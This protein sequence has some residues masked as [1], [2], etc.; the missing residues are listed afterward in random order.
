[1]ASVVSNWAARGGRR[2]VWVGAVA[3]VLLAGAAGVSLAHPAAPAS[4]TAGAVFLLEVP[5]SSTANQTNSISIGLDPAGGM[6]AGFTTIS[7]DG[8]GNHHA[9]YDFCAAGADC[10]TTANWTR[11]TLLTVDSDTTLMHGGQL[12][13]NAQGDPR[14]V[15]ITG[16]RDD[17]YLDHYHYAACDSGCT[18]FANWT[19]VDVAQAG[20]GGNTFLSEGNKHFF[21]LDPQGRPRFVLDNGSNYVYAACNSGCTTAGNWSTLELDGPSGGSYGFNTAAL[22]FDSTGHPRMLAPATDQNT[23]HTHLHYYECNASDCAANA[24]SWSDGPIILE[25]N[26]EQAV[27]SSLRLTSSGQPRFGYYGT[28]SSAEN[29]LF[30]MWCNSG[31]TTA[32]NWTH[33]S[34]GLVPAHDFD[35]SGKSPDLA[36]DAAGHPRLAFQTLEESLGHGL[37]YAW[38][39][40]NCESAGATWEKAVID[41]N[42]Q[43]DLDWPRNPFG[44]AFNFWVGGYR[45]SLVLAADGSPRIGHDVQHFT[46]QCSQPSLAGVDYVAVRFVYL[47]KDALP[48]QHS[49]FVPFVTR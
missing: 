31:C 43:M 38:C 25:M 11:V 42:D 14:M 49:V 16:D 10:A 20:L 41:T 34:V 48:S 17:P 12:Q 15:I 29:T 13:V 5:G 24:N 2:L 44:C 7:P 18:S 39:D 9:Y 19:V 47:P 3:A 40:A 8:S 21:A 28:F 35:R 27:Y 32:G 1:M 36:L 26:G 4:P 22:A 46:S 37:G 6:H 30:Y 33:R 23:F 45:P